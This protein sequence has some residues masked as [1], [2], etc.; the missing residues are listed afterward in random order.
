VHTFHIGAD[1]YS[2]YTG[3]IALAINIVVAVVVQLV[4]G[5]GG[6]KAPAL[7]H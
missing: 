5:K 4:F 3:L 1:S 2:M 7:K 6:A